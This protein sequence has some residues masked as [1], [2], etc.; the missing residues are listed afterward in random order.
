[1]G[2]ATPLSLEDAAEGLTA[3]LARGGPAAGVAWLEALLTAESPRVRAW[4]AWQYCGVA[5]EVP[6]RRRRALAR[7]ALSDLAPRDLLRTH[8]LLALDR[9]REARE[10]FHARVAAGRSS[11]AEMALLRELCGPL[12][13]P[14]THLRRDLAGAPAVEETL[15][16]A[17]AA[18]WSGGASNRVLKLEREGWRL[19]V[20]PVPDCLR[21]YVDGQWRTPRARLET[22]DYFAAALGFA[23]SRPFRLRRRLGLWDTLGLTGLGHPDLEGRAGTQLEALADALLDLPPD[24]AFRPGDPYPVVGVPLTRSRR[25]PF[26][27]VAVVG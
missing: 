3:R 25:R 17:A 11:R 5:L 21:C 27:P 16:A 2:A 26:R 7:A 22:L 15:Q 20:I 18:G 9:R 12:P 1:M 19:L 14:P 13:V 6:L 23:P 4:A 24:F 10:A 8:L